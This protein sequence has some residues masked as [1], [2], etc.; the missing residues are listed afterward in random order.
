MSTTMAISTWLIPIGLMEQLLCCWVT[1][2][3]TSRFHRQHPYFHRFPEICDDRVGSVGNQN[4]KY[5][6]CAKLYP[7]HFAPWRKPS[8]TPVF[9]RTPSHRHPSGTTTCAGLVALVLL[10][11]QHGRPLP[12]RVIGVQRP[13]GR[14]LPSPTRL[15]IRRR[16]PRPA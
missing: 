9:R 7:H 3:G 5:K 12:L 11:V 14:R 8:P 6:A 1:G 16:L 4:V 13:T 2:M 10:E 15:Q